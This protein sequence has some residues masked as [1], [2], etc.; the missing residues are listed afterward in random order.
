MTTTDV[1][2]TARPGEG[3]AERAGRTGRRV[4]P[5]DRWSW[6]WLLVGAAL[7]TVTSLQTLVPV[8]A[9]LAPVFL[10]RFVR[11]QRALVGL[12][13]VAVATCLAMLVALR[14]GF[15][16]IPGGVGYAVFIAGLGVG[17]TLP[18]ALDRL[19]A[20]RSSGLARILIFPAAVT[21]AEFVGT[22]GNPFGTAGSTAYSQYAN[23][24]L[25]QL[26]SV[27]GIWGLTFLVSMAAPVVNE[28]WERG[29]GDGTVR[30]GSA[31][32]VAV[33]GAALAFGG[34][35]LAFAA[36]AG[37]TVRVAA[38]A[39]DRELSE[40]AYSG[41]KLRPGTA[42]E[43]VA[44][45]EQHLTPVLDDLFTRSQQE[46]RAGAKIVSWSEAAAVVLE[47]DKDAMVARAAEL[48]EREQVYLQVAM[49]VLLKDA[50]VTGPVNENRAV[51][52]DPRG[53][54]AWDYEKSKPVPGDG[55]GA[56]PGVI[57][58]VDT[59]YGRLATVICQ[60][61]FFPA[62][63]RQAGQADVDILLVPSSDWAPITAWHAQQAPFR[64]VENGVAL[65]RATRQGVSLTTDA[66]GRLAG[67]K[68][69]YFVADDQ[70]LVSSVPVD[71]VDTVYETL[72]DG[73]AYASAAGL[74]VLTGL[75]L[76]RRRAP[77]V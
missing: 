1:H 33:L 31:L 43:R 30:L 65:V 39:P 51:L 71:G 29:T 76:R 19:L 21:T 74:V 4:H 47:E 55:N 60:D 54:V 23:L 59:P 8:A 25:L 17:G 77:A 53:N 44:V 61:D 67:Y 10:L 2:T 5:T 14:D 35:R 36:P 12:P 15:L 37:E 48:A 56:G 40:L 22:L 63:L 73:F 52:L 58:V 70:T 68:A 7:L 41:P 6:V 20:P 72:G 46:A 18:F 27:T 9:W 42:A 45:R 69:D 75:A 16:P 38:L 32:L 11:T 34:V 49:I 28:L 62:L 64:A 26:V 13:A 66:Q 3:Q 24:P 57:P 50:G